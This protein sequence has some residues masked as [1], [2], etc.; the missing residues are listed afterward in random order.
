MMN[1]R[2]RNGL[3]RVELLVA[4]ACILLVPAVVIVVLSQVLPDGRPG[5]VN[6]KDG[7]QASQI[8]KSF[9]I[10]ADE[11]GGLFPRPGLLDRKAVEGLG[12]VPNRGEEDVDLNTT[13]NLYSLLIAQNFFTPELTISPLERN[14]N[15]TVDLDYNY[16]A[17]QP[18][19][20]SYWD[21]SFNADLQTGSNV[22]YAHQP[23]VGRNAYRVWTNQ[24]QIRT[25]LVGSR[26]PKDGI[27]DPNSYSCGPNGWKGNVV[28][29]DGVVETFATTKPES[30]GFDNL[31]AIDD[32]HEVDAFLTFTRLIEN[33]VPEWQFD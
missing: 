7:T 9:A 22:S 32:H 13:A 17:Y 18:E 6:I 16:D 24:R 5:A 4:L 26:G 28:F 25:A 20:D 11:N 29:N 8:Y 10:F 12:D 33:G 14:P 31:F 23:L 30:L 19:N 21:P 2:V 1:H 3:T 15:V 27:I